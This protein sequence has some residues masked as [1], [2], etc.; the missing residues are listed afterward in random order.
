ME[1]SHH[2]VG[3]AEDAGGIDLAQFRTDT[4]RRGGDDGLPGLCGVQP[5][6]G[7][8]AAAVQ[9]RPADRPFVDEHHAQPELCGSQG[10]GIAGGPGSKNGEVEFLSHVDIVPRPRFRASVVHNW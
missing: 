5:T 2:T 6:L 8:D 1:L 3:V 10:A 7:G 9:A 4:E